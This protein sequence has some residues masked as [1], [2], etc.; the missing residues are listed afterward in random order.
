MSGVPVVARDRP[1]PDPVE[2]LPVESVA[3]ALAL[4]P[5][6]CL[7][8]TG[9][10]TLPF[11]SRSDD[12]DLLVVTDCAE[13]VRRAEHRR[14]TE[15]LSEQR[16]NGFSLSYVPH[17]SGELDVEVWPL[18]VVR[19]A[20]AAVGTRRRT[21]VEIEQ[22]FTRVGGLETKVGTDLFHALRYG[23]ALHGGDAFTALRETVCWPAYFAGKRD[24]ALVNVRDA[25]KGIAKSLGEDR[26][27]EAY[28]KL[29]WAADSVA[30]AMIFHHGHSIA[31]WKWR[32]RYLD[33]LGGWV[34][35]W[36]AAVRFPDSAPT[37]PWVREHRETLVRVWSTY[38]GTP[39]AVGAAVPDGA[40]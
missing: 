35:D 22:D 19:T 4:A 9:S 14:H 8:L 39:P 18:E 29:C 16:A 21:V 36:Y 20:V 2:R 33:L 11:P 5:A 34:R 13:T 37:V 1:E 15:R 10:R 23:R 30:D 32:L 12:V 38:A 6:D 40:R 17:E 3:A 24:A 31:R 25:T 28:L 26:P 27:D 7:V